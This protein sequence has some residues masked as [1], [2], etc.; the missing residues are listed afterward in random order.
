MV[1]FSRRISATLPAASCLQDEHH[2]DSF[3]ALLARIPEAPIF[4]PAASQY[5]V[6]ETREPG[7]HAA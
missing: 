6:I 4:N 5:N 3:D 1:Q 7:G 2:S